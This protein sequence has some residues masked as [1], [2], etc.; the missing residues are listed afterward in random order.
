MATTTYRVLGNIY[1]NGQYVKT[2]SFLEFDTSKDDDAKAVA[3]LLELNLIAEA[4]LKPSPS[5][6]SKNGAGSDKTSDK[7][8]A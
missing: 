5:S 4:I 2:D 1:H 8:S 6:S 7:S 3:R